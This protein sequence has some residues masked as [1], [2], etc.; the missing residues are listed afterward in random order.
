MGRSE[1]QDAPTEQSVRLAYQLKDLLEYTH[2]RKSSPGLRLHQR[3]VER[4][5]W[6]TMVVRVY[7]L[8]EP[9]RG[10]PHKLRVAREAVHLK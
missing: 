6:R 5:G 7:K 8:L 10:S 3:R 4:P 2:T 1:M 9:V